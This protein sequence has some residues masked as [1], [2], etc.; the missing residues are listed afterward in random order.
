MSFFKTLQPFGFSY[1]FKPRVFG[2][3]WTLRA[4]IFTSC[5][6]LKVTVKMLEQGWHSLVIC[7]RRQTPWIWSQGFIACSKSSVVSLWLCWLRAPLGCAFIGAQLLLCMPLRP[8]RKCLWM[9]KAYSCSED[10]DSDRVV[11]HLEHVGPMCCP[12]FVWTGSAYEAEPLG[13]KKFLWSDNLELL[14]TSPGAR[15]FW[16]TE[17][18]P[19]VIVVIP[20]LLNIL[21][22]V[23]LCKPLSG[24][25]D[26]RFE[27]S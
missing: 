7:A 21:E 1:P 16:L 17:H 10:S 14:Q 19:K 13:N 5:C 22:R 12:G 9:R 4:T 24:F 25:R 2:K 20:K 18:D 8:N 6:L 3:G 11:S 27:T 15:A 26:S 23:H